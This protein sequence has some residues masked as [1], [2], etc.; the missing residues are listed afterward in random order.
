MGLSLQIY[1]LMGAYQMQAASGAGLL[2]LALSVG[3]FWI[4]DRGGRWHVAA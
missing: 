4:L 3:L 1:R 2:L